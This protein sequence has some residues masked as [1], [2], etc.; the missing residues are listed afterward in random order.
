MF[1]GGVGEHAPTVRAD[2][3]ATLGHLGIRLD[4]G[5][6]EAGTGV[7]ST[8]GSPCEVRVVA[9]DEEL[10]IARHARALVGA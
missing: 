8:D 1:T 2:A 9:T 7:I 6:N 4:P 5:R 10:V 3:C